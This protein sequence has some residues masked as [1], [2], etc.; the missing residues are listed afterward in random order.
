MYSGVSLKS[1]PPQFC[2][3]SVPL[4]EDCDRLLWTNLKLEFEVCE[5]S[6]RP[7]LNLINASNKWHDSWVGN[8][9]F[10]V[11]DGFGWEWPFDTQCNDWFDPCCKQH[12]FIGQRWNV[13]LHDGRLHCCW[14]PK[15]LQLQ[16]KMQ[17][18]GR[19]W[20]ESCRFCWPK[21]KTFQAFKLRSCRLRRVHYLWHFLSSSVGACAPAWGR[22]SWKSLKLC[23]LVAW[24]GWTRRLLA[25]HRGPK[26]WSG[27]RHQRPLTKIA[28]KEL[29]DAWRKAHPE[30]LW[31]AFHAKVWLVDS[32]FCFGRVCCVWKF[33]WFVL[34]IKFWASCSCWSRCSFQTLRS[35]C[36]IVVSWHWGQLDWILASRYYQ[37][38][39]FASQPS[40]SISPSWMNWS[41][42]ISVDWGSLAEFVAAYLEDS[43]PNHAPANFLVQ[44]LDT[45]TR[46]FKD[47][48]NHDLILEDVTGY[49][50]NMM[51]KDQGLPG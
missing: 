42:V 16:I 47:E 40:M 32:R 44:F 12:V 19:Q 10:Q 6:L 25:R 34:K 51:A 8:Y 35:P 27:M 28:R 29:K 37:D 48:A 20:T 26:S 21:P 11:I 49:L 1:E 3:T 7:N 17:W 38:K 50:T 13:P 22:S 30:Q 43:G 45:M 15:Q 14:G 2:Q 9:R 24:G 18:C 5:P 31:Y 4:G 41:S 23:C 33:V 39:I 36:Q 46:L